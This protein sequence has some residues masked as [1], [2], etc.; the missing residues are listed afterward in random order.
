MLHEDL[1]GQAELLA[2]VD[3]RRPRQANLRRAVSAADY[4][5]FHAIGFHVS[6]FLTGARS[7]DRLARSLVRRSLT[8]A[9]IAAAMTGFASG[10]PARVYRPAYD[11]EA[12]MGA[13]RTAARIFLRLRELRHHA[14][15]DIL[16][17]FYRSDVLAAIEDA[18]DGIRLLA[19]LRSGDS[20]RE[21]VFFLALL[22]HD[23]LKGRARSLA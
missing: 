16:F 18:R 9:T 1:L 4:A 8:H 23:R 13:L 3:E 7:G 5:L 22:L 12:G 2:R 19:D 15:Y 6:R 17:V 11:R 14:D 20:Q 10:N 21:R